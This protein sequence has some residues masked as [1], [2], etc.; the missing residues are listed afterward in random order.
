[1]TRPIG[2]SRATRLK[3]VFRRMANLPL[4]L[5]DVCCSGGHVYLRSDGCKFHMLSNLQSASHQDF[6]GDNNN[7]HRIGCWNCARSSVKPHERTSHARS[8]NSQRALMTGGANHEAWTSPMTATAAR[9][10]D[11]PA[12]FTSSEEVFVNFA[13]EGI[14]KYSISS[15]TPLEFTPAWVPN[16]GENLLLIALQSR[17]YKRRGL[18]CF[19]LCPCTCLHGQ[20]KC[21]RYTVSLWSSFQCSTALCIWALPV[22]TRCISSMVWPTPI[23]TATVILN[24]VLVS[25]LY[26]TFRLSCSTAAATIF[27]VGKLSL[28]TWY[29]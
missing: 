24:A 9:P 17:L 6:V 1:M 28:Q 26:T 21:H 19:C 2:T 23:A 3:R 15:A 29:L 16:S 14:S 18:L 4:D 20:C 7:K 12:G 11:K 13:T 27:S 25:K 5:W 8:N 10:F 22:P